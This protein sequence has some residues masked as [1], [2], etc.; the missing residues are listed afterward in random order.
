MP[1]TSGLVALM[2][3]PV[4]AA[5]TESAAEIVRA[6]D[7]RSVAVNVPEPEVSVELVG[8]VPAGSVVLNRTV[9]A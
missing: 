7:V 8:T 1:P 3:V 4:T 5:F 2:A 9:P 6:P